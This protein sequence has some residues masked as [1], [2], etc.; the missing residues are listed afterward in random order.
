[1][2]TTNLARM[3]DI[4]RMNCGGALDGIIRAES[5]NVLK[6]FFQRT[7]AWLLEIT[8]FIVPTTNDYQI[9]TG[10]NVIVNR[11]MS[12]ERPRSPPTP[13][14]EFPPDYLPMCP[15]Q[16]LPVTQ[17]ENQPYSEAQNPLFRTRRSGVL[18]NAGTKCPLLRISQNPAANETWIATL[19]LNICDPLD[20]DGF[21]SPPD[22]IME[23]YLDYLAS[24][25]CKRLMLQ[26]GKP[27]SSQPGASYHGRKYNEGVGLARTEARNMF[28]YGA[29]RWSF[30]GGWNAPRP[31]LPSTYVLP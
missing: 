15:P 6:E 11:L 21:A 18:L 16:Y 1:M 17:S 28:T 23:K 12:L 26:A 9:E 20:M 2:T 10:Q 31:R 3:Q 5:F 14:G 24:G 7:N 13:D 29:Q 27:Y 22:W 30:P 4:V 8:V 25:V 19:A